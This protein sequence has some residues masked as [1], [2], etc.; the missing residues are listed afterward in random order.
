MSMTMWIVVSVVI[1]VIV[2]YLLAMRVLA[3]QSR[4]TD[5]KIDYSKIREWKDDEN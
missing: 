2:C 3:R 5:S 1:A 4:D